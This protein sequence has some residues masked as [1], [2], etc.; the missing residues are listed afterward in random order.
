MQLEGRL[1][2]YFF[3]ATAF[4]LF[5]V[6]ASAATVTDVVYKLSDS[7]V[8][9]GNRAIDPSVTWLTT[10]GLNQTVAGGALTTN[11][12]VDYKSSFVDTNWADVLS[13][14]VAIF[15]NGVEKAFI[16]FATAGTTK[17]NFFALKNG[18]GSSWTNLGTGSTHN[19]FAAGGDNTVDRNWFVNSSY[20]GCGADVGNM[21]IIQNSSKS[22]PC[23]WANNRKATVGEN[24]RAF[25]Y[26]NTTADQN[27]TTG[28]IGVGDVFAIS[29]TYNV[30]D[31]APVPLPA[32]A[33][34]LL[35]ALGGIGLMR[36]RKR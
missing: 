27:W 35:A 16:T 36:R 2:K 25:L 18:T 28:N 5:A 31:V 12:G 30:P 14:R 3:L 24:T 22:E 34:L 8:H 17:T 9:V 20:G 10:G 13:A 6:S 4:C 23:G 33:P 19:F 11:N 21:V 1:M 29:V 32:A 26:S 15:K 7:S